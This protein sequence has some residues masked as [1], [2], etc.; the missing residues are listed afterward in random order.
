MARSMRLRRMSIGLLAAG[1]IVVPPMLALPVAAHAAGN[2]PSIAVINPGEGPETGATRVTIVGHGFT[3][4]TTVT[5]GT[6]RAAF[7]V[8]SATQIEASSPAGI[9]GTSVDVRVGT[10]RGATAVTR[11]DR[12]L[13]TDPF[14]PRI[15]S[16]TPSSGAASGGIVHI[17]GTGL[18]DTRVVQFGAAAASHFTVKSDGAVVALSPSGKVGQGVDVAVI[19][20]HGVSAR[21]PGTRY[22]YVA[23]ASPASP[24]PVGGTGTRFLGSRPSP[25]AAARRLT[26]RTASVPVIAGIDPTSGPPF[27]GTAVTVIGNGF[28]SASGVSFGSVGCVEF[29]AQDDNALIAISPPGT[30]GQTVDIVVTSAAGSSV[31]GQSD[32]FTYAAV[33]APVLYGLTPGS[34]SSSGG[35]IVSIYGK[36]VA[37]VATVRFGTAQA[38]FYSNGPAS[39]SVVAPSQGSNPSTVDVVLTTSTGSSSAL[40]PADR[41]TFRA[42]G[43]PIINAVLPAHGL[44]TGGDYVTLFGSGFTGATDVKFGITHTALG[45]AAT[46]GVISIQ[47]PPQGTNPATV[48]IVVTTPAGSS[49]ITNADRYTYE[50]PGVPVIDAIDLNQGLASGG[51]TVSLFGSG[52]TGASAVTFGGVNGTIKSAA[53]SGMTVVSPPGTAASTVP[54]QVVTPRGTSAAGAAANFTYVA[55]SPPIIY[56]VTP[57]HGSVNGGTPVSIYGSGFTA[58]TGV[59]FGS[60]AAQQFTINFDSIYAVSP[61]ES[62]ATIDIQVTGPG[63][64]SAMAAPDQFTYEPPPQPAVHGFYPNRGLAV[65]ST[66]ITMFGSGFKDLAPPTVMFGATQATSVSVLN[67]LQLQALSP[68]QGGNPSSVDVTVVTS[69]GTSAISPADH[70]TFIPS[71]L[72]VVSA[73]SPNHGPTSGGTLVYLTG[74]GLTAAT[75]V[76]FGGTAGTI[77]NIPG[78]TLLEARSP[79]GGAGA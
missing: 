51:T 8:K 19:T 28:S 11:S 32:R 48:D 50:A 67:D 68:P 61:A 29:F 24:P 36:G 53:D 37:D 40:T 35:T 26:T 7:V 47:S 20:S 75:A 44:S 13:Y 66:W 45:P 17:F 18:R 14:V 10:D 77:V 16:L 22:A 42:P 23:T 31:T 73:A 78:D 71:P 43:A 59:K 58:A 39:L 12:F 30:L 74:S 63:G 4:V 56:G 41:Y 69:G 21:S 5:F 54:I 34:G 72:P 38:N 65:G 1:T 64:T 9:R 70:F 27:G 46:D 2:T 55:L 52:F 60:V 57:N 33:S 79:P 25:L 62:A 6:M 49:L 76:K 15:T 3:H